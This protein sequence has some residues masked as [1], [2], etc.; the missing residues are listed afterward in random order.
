VPIGRSFAGSSGIV[1][2]LLWKSTGGSTGQLV[3]RIWQ[4][5]PTTTTCVDNVAFAGSDADDANLITAPF[6]IFPA[7]PSSAT[8]DSATYAGLSA[9]SWDYKNADWPQPGPNLYV[10]AVTVNTDTA[11]QNKLVRVTLSGP[12]N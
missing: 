7:A 2:N 5:N 12:Q 3:I 4:K 1:T 8:G 10:C 6:S 9:L 11:D